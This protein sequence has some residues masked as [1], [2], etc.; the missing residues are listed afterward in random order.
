MNH[1]IL[2]L[3]LE[4]ERRDCPIEIHEGDDDFFGLDTSS[5]VKTVTV[6]IDFDETVR[7]EIDITEQHHYLRGPNAY[8]EQE[9]AEMKWEARTESSNR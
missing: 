5:I 1:E 2:N 7:G 9:L 3:M 6:S 8:D 4:A